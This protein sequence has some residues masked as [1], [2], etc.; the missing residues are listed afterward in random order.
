[1]KREGSSSLLSDKTIA[2]FLESKA[3]ALWRESKRGD[4]VALRRVESRMDC[5][6]LVAL[7]SESESQW[8]VSGMV[9]CHVVDI[10]EVQGS[11][12][13]EETCCA[14]KSLTI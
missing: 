3:C 2:D 4:D 12:S 7:L 14:D 9:L 5:S 1:M 8:L 10:P 13:V 6:G 11:L